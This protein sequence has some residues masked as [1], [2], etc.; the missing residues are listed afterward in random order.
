MLKV[1]RNI[2][3]F[4]K[5]TGSLPGLTTLLCICLIPA[6]MDPSF[7]EDPV[8][9]DDAADSVDDVV[10][11]LE[12]ANSAFGADRRA[13]GGGI[14]VS[15]DPG[16][17]RDNDTTTMD[18]LG[19]GDD[20]N[21]QC[22]FDLPATSPLPQTYVWLTGDF[23]TPPWPAEI[24]Q[25]AVEMALNPDSGLWEALV[26]LANGQV[27]SYKYL[28]GWADEPGPVW[29]NDEGDYSASAENSVLPVVCGAAP[30]DR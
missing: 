14:Q 21:C 7:Y 22:L 26:P 18:D 5:W 20:D 11:E 1:C 6:C 8:E 27:V 19:G 16:V 10:E 2:V 17:E 30:C 29:G 13:A 25:G 3:S 9:P 24:D 28:A 15:E 12:D 4:L 23:L